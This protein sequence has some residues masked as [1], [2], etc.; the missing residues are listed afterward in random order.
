MPPSHK[1]TF[2]PRKLQRSSSSTATSTSALAATTTSSSAAPPSPLTPTTT[3][4]STTGYKRKSSNPCKAA[5]PRGDTDTVPGV[6][7]RIG[8]DGTVEVLRA[9]GNVRLSP[10]LEDKK[11]KAGR[12]LS[13]FDNTLAPPA[14]AAAA[15]STTTSSNTQ[16]RKDRTR[17]PAR[18][19]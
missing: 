3:T 12:V 2:S 19:L 6:V 9:C 17:L 13:D 14:A 16:Q 8:F 15:G 4:T 18:R 1:K 5:S 7:F 11:R 10:S